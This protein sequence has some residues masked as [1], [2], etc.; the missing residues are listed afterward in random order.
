MIDCPCIDCLCIAVCRQKMFFQLA[1]DC[2]LVPQFV[3]ITKSEGMHPLHRDPVRMKTLERVLRP[4]CWYLVVTTWKD[5]EVLIIAHTKE[6]LKRHGE[7]R[8][9]G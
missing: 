7:S 5:K 2:E 6:G 1:N 9:E 3:L 8:S 4:E